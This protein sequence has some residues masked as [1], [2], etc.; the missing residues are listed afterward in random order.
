MGREKKFSRVELWNATRELI[1]EVGYIGFT[2]S[3]LAE[4]LH[5]SRAAI[6]KQFHVKE[7]LIIDYMVYEMEYSIELLQSIDATKDFDTQLSDLLRKMYSMKDVH[8][9]L[10]FATTIPSI[11]EHVTYQKQKLSTMHRDLY[12][13]LVRIIDKGK[14][15]G[16]IALQRSSAM[17]LGFIFQTIDV[18]NFEKLTS[19]DLVQE[20]KEFILYGLI[21]EKK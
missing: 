8:R 13:P 20:M 10:G 17:L 19:E 9:A 3:L 12:A 7:E 11:T 21:G 6:Y 4:K 5:I 14:E 15:E 1:L 2:F 16:K 18:P